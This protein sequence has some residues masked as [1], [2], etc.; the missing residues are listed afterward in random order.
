MEHYFFLNIYN[1][2]SVIDSVHSSLFLMA[3]ITE[4]LAGRAAFLTLL[5]FS[6]AELASADELGS[7]AELVSAETAS[8]I[9]SEDL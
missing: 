9:C 1:P 4:T 5:P 6:Q 2:F 7:S 3:K 8:F